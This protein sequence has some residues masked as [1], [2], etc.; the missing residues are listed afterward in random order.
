MAIQGVFN[1]NMLPSGRV[2]AP[3][4]GAPKKAPKKG[5]PSLVGSAKQASKNNDN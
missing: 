2:K 5:L 1:A 4:R 3:R